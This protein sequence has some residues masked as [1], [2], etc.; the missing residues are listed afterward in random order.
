MPDGPRWRQRRG[1]WGESMAAA[2]YE[3]LGGRV[4]DRNWRGPDGELDLVVWD[5]SHGRVVFVEVRTRMSAAFGTAEES[6]TASKRRHWRRT[7]AAWLAAER[8]GARRLPRDVAVCLELA[9][10]GR[11]ADG[12]VSVTVVADDR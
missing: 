1:A 11:A 10:V 3:A 2:H 7:A 8:T 4:L 12:S 6:V 9:A 5:P